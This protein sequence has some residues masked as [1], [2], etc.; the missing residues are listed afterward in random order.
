[1]AAAR[2]TMATGRAG[3]HDPAVLQQIEQRVAPVLGP[4]ATHLVAR[5]SRAAATLDD[6]CRQ[7]ASFIPSSE[8]RR[9]FLAW[10]VAELHVSGARERTS[11]P[12]P[13][14][15][16]PPV[17]DP[18]ALEQARRDLAIHLGPLARIIVRR[19]SH[20]AR[21]LTELYELL[22]LE[23]PKEDDRRAFKRRAPVD[24]DD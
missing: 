16:P 20:R 12:R 15:T 1:M 4:V 19:V 13:P 24:V 10:S 7:I 6:L 2:S 11:T 8:D 14:G 9:A 23:I 21:D 17:W 3:A 18:A 22:A 5:T